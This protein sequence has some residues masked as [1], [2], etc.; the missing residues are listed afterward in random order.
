VV[1][2]GA[3]LFERTPW[4][5]DAAVEADVTVVTVD[6][7]LEVLFPELNR[8]VRTA[9]LQMLVTEPTTA[10]T[11]PRPVYA[12]WGYDYWQQLPD[13][14][15]AIGGCRDRFLDDEWST[16]ATPTDAVQSC[17]EAVLRDRA[18]VGVP[19]DVAVTHRWAGCAAFTDDHMPVCEEVR[20]GVY[21]VGG[22]SGTGNVL[23]A[24]Y[25]RAAVRLALGR[26]LDELAPLVSR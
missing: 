8:R 26:P 5:T 25:G 13:G 11:I 12:R 1:E 16:D 2:R 22:Y 14:R 3:R 15:V 23:G 9:R 19:S 18:G 7:G 20:P 10:V 4:P 17:I 24:L 6:G 21:A